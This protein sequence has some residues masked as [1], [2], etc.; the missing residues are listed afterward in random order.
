MKRE[1]LSAAKSLRIRA[2]SNPLFFNNSA[3]SSV[4]A[5]TIWIAAKARFAQTCRASQNN[6]TIACAVHR[7]A[8][9]PGAD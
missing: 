6:Q 9:R 3:N 8:S 2:L 5:N 4:P 1:P 7:P